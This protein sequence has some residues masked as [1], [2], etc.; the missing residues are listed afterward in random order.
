MTR[1]N[2]EVDCIS[3]RDFL[4]GVVGGTVATILGPDFAACQGRTQG[5]GDTQ[6]KVQFPA[7]NLPVLR[8]ADVVIA[9]G[10]FAA[11]AAAYE[12]A[13][14]GKKV[15]LVESRTYLGREMTATLRPWIDLGKLAGQN[16]IPQSVRACLD[17]V[18]VQQ[19]S[20]E[21]ALKMD[22]VKIALEDLLLN[23]GVELLYASQPIGVVVE[24][25]RIAGLVIGNKSGRQV[26]AGKEFIDATE[27][28]AVARIAGAEFE[29]PSPDMFRFRRTI[30]FDGAEPIYKT[31]LSV[32][33]DLGFAGN[34]IRLHKGYRGPGHIFVD[35]PLLLQLGNIDMSGLMAR[36]IEARHRCMRLV[37][38]LVNNVPDFKNAYTA[39]TSF[40]LYGRLTTRMA[41]VVPD[42]A[43]QFDSGSFS[44]TDKNLNPISLQ[45][46]SFAAALP[47]LWCLQEAARLETSQLEFF[48]DPVFASLVGSG[49]A[50]RVLD[51]WEKI[52]SVKL[53]GNS[54]TSSDCSQ[55][56]SGAMAAR[57]PASPQRGRF[58]ELHQ[59]AS[60]EA[61]VI[62][63][64]DVLVVGGGTSGATAAITSAKEGLRTV[65]L[66]LNPG[67]GGTGTLGGVNSYWFGR[68]VG[69]CSQVKHLVANV[70]DKIKQGGNLRNVEGKK[71]DHEE[72]TRTALYGNPWNIEA[73]MYALL[74]EA[75][76]AGVEVFFSTA[77]IAAVVEGNCIR[78][79]VAAGKFG[80]FAVLAKV[81]IDATGDG[82]IAAFAGAEYQYGS[83]RD[84]AVMWYS[85]AQFTRPGRTQNNFTSTV[86]VSNI[87]DYTRAVIVGRRR[88]ADVCHD[89]GIYIASRETRHIRGGAVLNL[90]DQL[91]K[92][93]WP[94]VV[95][96]H[97]SNC[98]IKGR[99]ESDWFHI[100]LVPPHMEI[101]IPYRA[102]LPNGL[103]NILIAGKAFSTTHMGLP[104]VR[105]QADLENLGGVVALAAARAVK[106]KMTPRKINLTKLQ[107]R[108]VKIGILPKQI[109]K[110]KIKPV[111][112]T[113]AELVTLVESLDAQKPL[114]A[115][116]DMEMGEVF[117]EKIPLVEVCTAGCCRAIPVLEQAFSQAEG[118]R[119]VLLSQMLA[120]C[121]NS[122]GVPD[123]IAA[124]EQHIAGGTLPPRTS[125]I[126]HAGLPPDQG[127]LPDVVYL[128]YSL[129]MT[130]DKRN[131]AIWK[132]VAELLSP[133]EQ[134]FRDRMKGTFYYVDAVC[135]GAELLG[136][137]EA[138]PILQ[139]L[140]SFPPLQNLVVTDRFDA[141]FVH[142]R[143]AMLE[144]A[145][146]RSLAR[147]GSPD[148]LKI[149]I[150]YL[151]DNRAILAEGAHSELAAITGCDYGKDKGAWN[152]W[153]SFTGASLK[154]RP[155]L[156]RPSG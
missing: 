51:H 17:A 104:A 37:R 83:E 131:L 113:D 85:L 130:R 86:D 21:A 91:R 100:G 102:L 35:C 140:H 4:G 142:E 7:S 30:E 47:A 74:S 22:S 155:V 81:V 33:A 10:S 149:L 46:A 62:R 118:K 96:I 120:M 3:R 8:R 29:G 98:D 132:K 115:Y 148:G 156:E 125:R 28:A 144:L 114:H 57:H 134:D 126:R 136:E 59:V 129:A 109:L 77:A 107:Q 110:R 45:T 87:E 153:L 27:T 147:C 143:Q 26:I 1:G 64:A 44:L 55:R 146:G 97:Y 82:D 108:L 72:V 48:A 2:K 32:P 138:I 53:K 56:W 63:E 14:A 60:S 151:Q 121:D 93:Q 152:N 75:E 23:A 105:M 95:N 106:E 122:A 19:V 111:L 58:Y 73:K 150:S 69:F 139:K 20:G 49:F 128:L 89:H 84:H 61:P 13:K 52:D 79:V 43:L 67:L 112:Y 41:D 25:G 11:V 5:A 16:F 70:Q 119:R 141:D 80:A 92:R 133:A 65:L 18:Q 54:Q 124:I 40:E 15:V 39:A 50:K 135:Y 78:G 137:P 31:S 90:T 38:H 76:R 103:E 101:E 71:P 36:E 9:G 34:E 117:R 42:W 68:H 6:V 145:I 99:A 127:A 154:P 94:D 66:E 24:E 116:S 12:F 88:A 123:L